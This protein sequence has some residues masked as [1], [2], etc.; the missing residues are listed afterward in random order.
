MTNNTKGNIVR[1]TAPPAKS[2]P[3]AVPARSTPRARAAVA[4]PAVVELAAAKPKHKLVRD[5]FTIPKSEYLV[6]EGL[7]LRAAKLTRPVKKSELLR[8]GISAL[9]A[10]SDKAFLAALNGVPS[11]KTGRPKAVDATPVPVKRTKQP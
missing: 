10:M 1:N 11:L 3:A 4:K 9:H 8:A 6:L 7:K 2:T 5:S